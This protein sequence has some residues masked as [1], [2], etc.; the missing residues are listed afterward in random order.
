MPEFGQWKFTV[1]REATVKAYAEASAGGSDTC[2][3]IWCRNFRLTR[4]EV[5]PEEF[6]RFL[7]ELGID[8]RKDAE[9]FGCGRTASGRH[10]YGGWYH[11]IGRLEETGD[12]APVAFGEDFSA[13]LLRASAPRLSTLKKAEVVELGFNSQA[14]PWRLDEPDP[15]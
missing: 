10:F 14:V 15:G 1:D 3:C 5:F 6:L 8:A 4:S 7:D 12:F 9:V 2:K 11:F 13:Y